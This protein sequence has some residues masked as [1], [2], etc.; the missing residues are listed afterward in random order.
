MS[1]YRGIPQPRSFER[2]HGVNPIPNS[3]TSIG[4]LVQRKGTELEICEKTKNLPCGKDR[5]F[6]LHIVM[7]ST[8]GTGTALSRGYLGGWTDE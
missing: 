2:V 7:F 8:P 1:T 4:I 5:K 6:T 3:S